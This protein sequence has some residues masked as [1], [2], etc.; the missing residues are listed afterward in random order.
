LLVGA[1]VV[2]LSCASQNADGDRLAADSCAAD[3]FTSVS[4]TNQFRSGPGE[5]FFADPARS[6]SWVERAK[7]RAQQAANAAALDSYWQPLA[8]SWG[9]AEAAARVAEQPE[10]AATAADLRL[11]YAMVTKDSYCRIAL[12]RIGTRL[13]ANQ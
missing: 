4:D 2:A 11:S 13:S 1:T 3:P 7:R 12:V 9:I 5:V 10:I 8:D 6:D